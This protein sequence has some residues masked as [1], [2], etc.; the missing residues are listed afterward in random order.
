MVAR[1]AV[2]LSNLFRVPSATARFLPL[3][4][5]LRVLIDRVLGD[6]LLTCGGMCRDALGGDKTCGLTVSTGLI[7]LVVSENANVCSVSGCGSCGRGEGQEDA[8]CPCLKA[9]GHLLSSKERERDRAPDEGPRVKPYL[10]HPQG[11]VLQFCY[12]YK[13][14]ATVSVMVFVVMSLVRLVTV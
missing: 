12:I 13:S 3:F 4:M 10:G 1:R 2:T 11:H 9:W 14:V 6:H 7:D 5:W 8:G